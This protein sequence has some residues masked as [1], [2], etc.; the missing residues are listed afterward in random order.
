MDGKES[1]EGM[2]VYQHPLT[3]AA[4]VSP[5]TSI[6]THLFLCISTHSFFF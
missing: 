1:V 3:T 5:T 6:Q 2:N 4:E